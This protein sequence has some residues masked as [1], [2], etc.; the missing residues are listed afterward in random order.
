MDHCFVTRLWAQH[1]QLFLFLKERLFQK[2]KTFQDVFVYG[3]YSE[4]NNTLTSD[5]GNPKWSTVERLKKFVVD[6]TE[7][8]QVIDY[9]TQTSNETRLACVI[10]EKTQTGLVNIHLFSI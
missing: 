4:K 1:C 8:Q 6:P 10:I 2:R 7:K 5:Y 3:V 9:V